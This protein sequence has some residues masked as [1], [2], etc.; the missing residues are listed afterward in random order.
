MGEYRPPKKRLHRD[1]VYLDHDSVLNSLSAFEAGRVDEIIEKTTEATDRAVEGGLK[2]GPAK[3]GVSRKR[4]SE[5]QGELVRK[6][7][8]F[9]AFES[10]YQQLRDEDAIGSFDVWDMNV[11]NG[12]R[13]GDTIEFQSRVRLSPLHLLFAT[14]AAYA[15]SASPTGPVFKVAAKDASEARNT[16]KMMQEWTRGP[17]GS[18]SS[19][20]YFE[21]AD[22]VDGSPRIIGRVAETYL[23]RGLGE[24]DGVFSVVA[25]VEA[26]L[27]PGNQLSAIRVIRDTPATPLET[28]TIATALAG[29]Q[30][31]ASE[32]MG[33]DVRDDDITYVHPAVIVRPIAIY[34]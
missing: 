22:A 31:A 25:Q 27:E 3:G 13:V 33:V 30:G 26:T 8:R 14:F 10:W 9:S 17:G 32:A 23:V 5:L 11:R 6:R 7:T 21:P 24:V 20:V 2:L 1:F 28:Q 4:E 18:Q 16:A 29:F 12:L 34:R 19:S 15:R